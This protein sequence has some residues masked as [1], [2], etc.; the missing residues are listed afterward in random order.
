MLRLLI[1][2]LSGSRAGGVDAFAIDS[3]TDILLGRDPASTIAFDPAHDDVVGR[4]HARIS[5]HEV[6]RTRFVITDLGSRNGTFVNRQRISSSVVLSPGDIVQLGP[7]GPEFQIDV[8]PPMAELPQLTRVVA[9][10]DAGST[11]HVGRQHPAADAAA[12][13]SSQSV[14]RA[15]VERM[16]H[17]VKVD[18]RKTAGALAVAVVGVL[19]AVF[20]L[21]TVQGSRRPDPVPAKTIAAQYLDTTVFIEANWKLVHARTGQQIHHEYDYPRDAAGR[22]R[23][24]D[25]GR[26]FAPRPLYVRLP[27]NTVEPLLALSSGPRGLNQPIGGTHVGTGFVVTAD[28]FILTNRHVAAAWETSYTGFPEGPGFLVDLNDPEGVRHDLD[29]PPTRWVPAAAKV[30]GRS[31]VGKKVEG[32]HTYLDVTF[33][34]NRL[35][36]PAS[37]A[38]VSDVHDVAMMKIQMPQALAHVELSDTY[39]TVAVG[40]TVTVIGYPALSPMVAVRMRSDDPFAQDEQTR[41]V[42]DPTVTPAAIG[43]ILRGRIAPNEQTLGYRSAIGDAYQI[44]AQPGSGNSGG[45]VFDARG[46]VIAI[47]TSGI[48][49]VMGFA[50][51]IR[52]G[53]ELMGVKPVM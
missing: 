36:V 38:R 5:R 49:E 34:R 4:R 26:A 7:G 8:D 30:I 37:V 43:R 2:H 31:I 1:R 20:G 24:D 44:T 6:D 9:R 28:G 10:P 45:P 52:F 25:K 14:G 15:T 18:S 32:S 48:G 21:T 22:V 23:R 19:A 46:R 39:D 50:V 33:A 42:P 41:L 51:P 40:E 17:A 11:R 16:V 47:Y 3:M 12:S 35:R 29:G 13:R 27:D 53:L